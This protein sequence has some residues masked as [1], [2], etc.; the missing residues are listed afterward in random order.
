MT[1]SLLLTSITGAI[2]NINVSGVVIKNYNGVAASW[3]S[4]PNVLYPNPEGFI[5]DFALSFPTNLRG[6]SAPQ[7]VAYTLNYRFLG[8]EVGDLSQMPNEYSLM[9][10]KLVLILNALQ[11]VDA[12]YSGLV[13]MEVVG[14]TVGARADPAGNI[15][16]GADIALR[17]TEMQNA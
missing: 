13:E 8:S 6:A 2:D 14:V 12:P 5:T 16:H 9:I 4:Q 10:D 15:F 7:D 3:Q 1:V 17:I 11:G